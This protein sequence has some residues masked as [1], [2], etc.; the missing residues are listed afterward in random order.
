MMKEKRTKEKTM[1][2]AWL[3]LKIILT[4]IGVVLL[5]F[6]GI[7]TI[8]SLSFS[9][10]WG[11]TVILGLFLFPMLLPLLWL[12][13]RK[14]YLIVYGSLL[15]CFGILVGT[16]VGINVYND[17][18]TI[19]VAPNINPHE[20]LPFDEESKIVRLDSQTLSFDGLPPE[21]L[22]IIDGATAA[23]PVY[24]AFVNAVYPETTK[25]YDGVFEYNN[26]VGGYHLLAQKKT[27]LFIGAYPSEEQI[28]FAEENGTA[29][30]YT[31]IGYEAFVFFVHKDNPI[32]SLTLEQI[33]GIYSGKI[34]NWQEVGGHD[35][36]IVPFQR[37][38][39]SGSQSMFLRL[40]GDTPVLEPDTKTQIGGMGEIIEEVADYKNKSTSIGFSFRYYVEGM[41]KNPDIKMIAV[42]GV[43]P[44]KENIKNGTYAIIAPV[45]AVTYEGNPK[46]SVGQLIEWILSEE[47]QYI[48]NETGYVGIGE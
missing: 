24:S 29:Y 44:T 3:V 47:G 18:I 1:K 11:I 2:T 30:A 9:G 43:A 26:T 19:D 7:V 28:A 31:Q 36:K 41:I 10:F 48:I 27:D 16:Q 14:T 8:V 32:E 45:Y 21:E 25:L 40:M 42:N 23:F 39:G 15:L 38:E 37:N 46:K 34:T 20:Y 22:P 17:S 35:E 5:P 13:K 33:K 12:E 6:V 4:V